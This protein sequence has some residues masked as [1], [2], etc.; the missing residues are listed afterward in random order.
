MVSWKKA[1]DSRKMVFP[2][3]IW[4][5]PEEAREV[6]TFAWIRENPGAKVEVDTNAI[7]WAVEKIYSNGLTKG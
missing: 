1:G 7:P 4:R 3:K 2:G 5:D 6:V